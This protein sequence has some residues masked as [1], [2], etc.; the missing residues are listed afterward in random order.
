[1]SPPLCKGD[2]KAPPCTGTAVCEVISGFRFTL[3]KCCRTE[4][5]ALYIVTSCLFPLIF[6]S[7]SEFLIFDS[8][9]SEGRQL[10]VSV[11]SYTFLSVEFKRTWA[12]FT[13]YGTNCW[14]D[15]PVAV[16]ES[17]T[18]AVAVFI[19]KLEFP[20]KLTFVYF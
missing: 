16:I 18:E 5:F 3:I 1:M 9:V 7:V 2:T 19:S 6:M 12:S 10:R 15:K 14:K 17:S 20:N 11:T 8:L 4:L 13:N